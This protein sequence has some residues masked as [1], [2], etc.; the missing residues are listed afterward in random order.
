MMARENA[1]SQVPKEFNVLHLSKNKIMND[2]ITAYT[3]L[4]V[5]NSQ[6]QRVK[7]AGKCSVRINSKKLKQKNNTNL[8]ISNI[9]AVTY[10]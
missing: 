8:E 9:S 2:P 10:C 5:K 1:L 6:S 3:P 4:I 7:L